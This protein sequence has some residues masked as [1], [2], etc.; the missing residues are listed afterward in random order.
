MKLGDDAYIGQYLSLINEI[1]AIADMPDNYMW[2]LE[3]QIATSA[4]D[5]AIKMGDPLNC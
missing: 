2:A 4:K 1:D 3:K 5:E